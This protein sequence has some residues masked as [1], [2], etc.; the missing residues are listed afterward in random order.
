MEIKLSKEMEFEGKKYE[1]LDLD[2]D[3]LTGRD[4]INAEKEA[5]VMLFRPATDIDKTYQV[6]V[7]ALACR[8]PSDM[9]M[10]LPGRDFSKITSEVQNFLL[11]V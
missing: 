6:C 4:L 9:L 11:G 1:A 8:V 3:A 7:A 10:S 2:L 5:S